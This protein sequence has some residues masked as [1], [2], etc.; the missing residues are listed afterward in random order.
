M[1][2]IGILLIFYWI[3]HKFGYFDDII[4]ILTP[5]RHQT[6]GWN[7]AVLLNHFRESVFRNNITCD[8]IY[9]LYFDLQTFPANTDKDSPVT[10]TFPE[11]IRTKLLRIKPTSW[12]AW[13]SLRFE[14]LGCLTGKIYMIIITKYIDTQE[15]HSTQIH[16]G[17]Y[18]HLMNSLTS[19][20]LAVH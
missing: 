6:H 12:N 13:V 16:L 20:V 10:I 17:S 18:R 1:I 15:N 7:S 19:L 4:Y 14:V 9:L 8:D 11:P 2:R 3:A 5:C